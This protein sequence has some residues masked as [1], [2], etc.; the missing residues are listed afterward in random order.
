MRGLLSI[1]LFTFIGCSGGYIYKTNTEC[2]SYLDYRTLDKYLYYN[3]S[4]VVSARIDTTKVNGLC[5][6]CHAIYANMALVNISSVPLAVRWYNLN[7]DLFTEYN[8][9]NIGLIFGDSNGT[10]DCHLFRTGF[11]Q[12][13]SCM[14]II[15]AGDSLCYPESLDLLPFLRKLYECYYGREL[16]KGDYSIRLC[17]KNRIIITPE[18]DTSC[19]A[20]NKFDHSGKIRSWVGK[21]YSEELWFSIK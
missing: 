3:D 15:P 2:Y 5:D 13:N 7:I 14:E 9:E 1:L 8:D 10:I 6:T 21:K 18:N 11:N 4:L 12:C 19:I 20:I 16:P 17:Y